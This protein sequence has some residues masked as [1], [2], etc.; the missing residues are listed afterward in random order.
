MRTPDQTAAAGGERWPRQP[1]E[2]LDRPGVA[3]SAAFELPPEFA[4]GDPAGYRSCLGSIYK[5]IYT[6]GQRGSM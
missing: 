1:G 3:G 2:R 5:V 6:Y 4:H